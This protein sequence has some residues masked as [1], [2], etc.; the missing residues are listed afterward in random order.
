MRARAAPG[1]GPAGS[2]SRRTR[3]PILVP[4]R[5]PS[6]RRGR[7]RG[8]ASRVSSRPAAIFPSR[9]PRRSAAPRGGRAR[10]CGCA[11]PRTTPSVRWISSPSAHSRGNSVS[12]ISAPAAARRSAAASSTARPSGC[13]SSQC[14]PRHRP[15]RGGGLRHRRRLIGDRHHRRAEQGDVV[16]RARHDADRVEGFGVDPHAGRRKQ[17]KARLE[18]DDAAIGRRTDHRAAGLRADRQRHHEIGDRR[19][20]A[21]RRAARR[22]AGVVRVRGR[23]GM[24]VGELGRHRLAEQDAAGRPRQ[25][26]RTRIPWRPP[27]G[28]DR[29]AVAGRHVGAVEDVLEAERHAVQQRLLAWPCRA[30]ALVGAPASP[31]RWLHA[32]TTGS[33]SAIRSRQL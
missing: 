33:R 7:R 21:A 23:P 30:R 25:C 22:E 11:A 2:G 6:R 26:R 28:I 17:A 19:R 8:N 5:A 16:D 10:A 31:A 12:P 15:R 14:G 29:R 9:K 18:P 4:P 13:A 20:R 24:A 1:R 32:R 3:R 27:A